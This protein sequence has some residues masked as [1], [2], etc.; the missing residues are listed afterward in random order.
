[1]RDEMTHLL[2][3]INSG[4]DEGVWRRYRQLNAKRRGETLSPAEQQELI[5]LVDQ[6]EDANARRIG[7]LVEL[8]RLRGV[9][10]D[11]VMSQ[12]AKPAPPDLGH[13]LPTRV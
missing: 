12:L 5:G 6:I 4:P 7:H 10:L 13:P 8:A 11:T 2:Q 1:M 9:T 3:Q